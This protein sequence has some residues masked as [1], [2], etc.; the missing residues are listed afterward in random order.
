MAVSGHIYQL[1]DL[2]GAAEVTLEDEILDRIDEIVAPGTDLNPSDVTDTG[3]EQL[4][5]V[6][7]AARNS[8]CQAIQAGDGQTDYATVTAYVAA[9]D[10]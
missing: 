7:S 6:T 10:R 3:G 9:R 8:A 4:M 1:E 2:L 5:P